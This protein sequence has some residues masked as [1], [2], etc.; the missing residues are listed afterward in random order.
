MTDLLLAETPHLPGVGL[1][2]GA[3]GQ[4]RVIVLGVAMTV[5]E[6]CAFAQLVWRRA[7]EACEGWPVAGNA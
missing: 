5:D 1:G 2:I 4:A 3:D 6:A 7:G